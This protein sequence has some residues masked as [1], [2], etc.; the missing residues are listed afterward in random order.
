MTPADMDNN[1]SHAE[2][3]TVEEPPTAGANRPESDMDSLYILPLS[4]IP[5]DTPGLKRARLLKD[6]RLQTVVEL[7][8]DPIAGSGR[9]YPDELGSAF[10]WPKGEIHPDLVTIRGLGS[11]NSYDVF[12]LRLELRRLKIRIPDKSALTLS[13]EKNRQLANY[14]AEFTRPLIQQVFG[15]S[16]TRIN[17]VGDLIAM[18]ARPD[19]EEAL[20]NLR[21]M[22]DQLEVEMEEVPAFL[23]DYGD[24]FMSLAYFREALDNLVPTITDFMDALVELRKNFQLRQDR[25]FINSSQIIERGFNDITASITGRFESFERHSQG[26]WE[27]I[28]AEAFSKVK[29]LIAAHHAT[30]GGVLC[31]LK[32]KMS[33]WDAR[34]AKGRGGPIERADFIMSEIKQGIDAIARIEAAAPKMSEA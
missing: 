21:L 7:F 3:S 18:F 33:A 8:N 9:L 20:K 17:D 16:D 27:N 10:D 29:K 13:E 26:M 12:S 32:V 1:V 11:L 23:E 34:F 31:G 15:S 2:P 6:S 24:I 25:N 5:L 28:T 4:M 30:I 14:M 22:A 19:K